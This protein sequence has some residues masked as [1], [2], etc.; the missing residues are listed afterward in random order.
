MNPP[1]NKLSYRY[2]YDPVDRLSSCGTAQNV[3]V[4]RF[5]NNNQLSTQIQGMLKDSIFQMDNFLLAQ[6]R[7]HRPADT[8][9]LATDTPGSV[10]NA[11]SAQS[12]KGAAY[13]SYGHRVAEIEGATLLGF[14]GECADLVTGHYLLGNGY[15]AYNP[16]LMRFNSPDSFSPFGEGGVNAYGYCAGDPINRSDEDGHAWSFW[17]AA[18]KRWNAV[19]K[20]PRDLST[21]RPLD[22]TEGTQVWRATS[23]HYDRLGAKR[24]VLNEIANDKNLFPKERNIA[25]AKYRDLR[26][27]WR[28]ARENMLAIANTESP[29]AIGAAGASSTNV[30]KLQ[31]NDVVDVQA[32]YSRQYIG[33]GLDEKL[34]TVAGKPIRAKQFESNLKEVKEKIRRSE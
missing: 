15:R 32:F 13:S 2:S 14:N 11:L 23:Q 19:F 29:F 30:R 1:K 9:L 10:L 4:Q 7:Q 17:G 21:N 25:V 8:A 5:Y 24:K 28:A 3:M 6:Q 12:N 34:F 20:A 31:F 26:P 33:A 22:L 27:E 16:V 18:R